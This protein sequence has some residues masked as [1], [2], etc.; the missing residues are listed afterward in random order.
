[1]KS[2]IGPLSD[3]SGD[4][5]PSARSPLIRKEV[6]DLFPIKLVDKKRKQEIAK[7]RL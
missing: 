1:M 2:S 5:A 6:I 4:A 3:L 7:M